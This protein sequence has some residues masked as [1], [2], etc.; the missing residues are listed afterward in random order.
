MM[1]GKGDKK[2]KKEITIVMGE[3]EFE[4]KD[5]FLVNMVD[6]TTYVRCKIALKFKKGIVE[7]DV[8]AHKGEISD[9][10][11][12]TLKA[13]D[14]KETST[15]ED[16]KKL[17]RRIAAAINAVMPLP[18]GEAEK[19]KEKEAEKDKADSEKKPKKTEEVKIKKH[20]EPA[21]ENKPKEPEIPE[22]WDSLEGPVLKV[23]FLSF[24][25]QG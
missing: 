23:L 3:E 7:H 11:N 6:N 24:A 14:P 1:K 8:E 13:T 25:T 2:D 19:E 21:E 16:M 15:L 5:E 12:L 18:H 20:E 9:A 10:I 22:D 4:L 17:K